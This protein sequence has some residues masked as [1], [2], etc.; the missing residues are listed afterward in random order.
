MYKSC[1]NVFSF[2]FFLI[3]LKNRNMSSKSATVPTIPFAVKK[4]KD[5]RSKKS[6]KSTKTSK[7]VKKK[8]DVVSNDKGLVDVSPETKEKEK[9]DGSFS[10]RPVSQIWFPG[11]GTKS[12]EADRSV[13]TAFVSQ[14]LW[15]KQKWVVDKDSQL[16]YSL[17]K[18]TI[19][20]FILSNIVL[21]SEVNK[22]IW[23]NKARRWVMEALN[24]V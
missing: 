1:T 3:K 11:H 14:S 2:G 20:G 18:K 15:H 8:G 24:N 7:S 13:V 6:G 4:G 10:S 17:E 5:G 23:W 9:D 22:G 12:A 19:C 21:S 16:L